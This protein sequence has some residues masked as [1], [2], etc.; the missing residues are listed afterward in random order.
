MEK[1]LRRRSGHHQRDK[2]RWQTLVRDILVDQRDYPADVGTL[3]IIPWSFAASERARNANE[4]HRPGEKWREW[5]SG[6]RKMGRDRVLKK[7]NKLKEKQVKTSFLP[8][9]HP[10]TFIFGPR[11][12][13][14]AAQTENRVPR[15]FCAPKLG[16]CTSCFCFPTKMLHLHAPFFPLKCSVS[17]K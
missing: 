11:F 13:S 2:T 3:D 10:A 7:D 9:P 15:S 16:F 14:R 17:P 1:R 4:S 12:I 6:E 8:H 5:N